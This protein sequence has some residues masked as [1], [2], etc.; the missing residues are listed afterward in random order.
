[1]L[2]DITVGAGIL[3]I[4]SK[5]YA[6]VGSYSLITWLVCAVV[7]LGID[8]CLAQ[9]SRCFQHS[10][11]RYLLALTAFGPTVGF[12]SGWLRLLPSALSYARPRGLVPRSAGHSD[13]PRP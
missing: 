1:M 9:V 12:A 10:G 7:V 3:G 6:L 11:G 4:P 2:S 5:V 8:L 13:V